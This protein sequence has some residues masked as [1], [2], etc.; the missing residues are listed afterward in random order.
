MA[1]IS[2][3]TSLGRRATS[4]VARAGASIGAEKAR[5]VWRELA[6]PSRRKTSAEAVADHFGFCAR[7]GA[8]LGAM[9]WPPGLASVVADG[10]GIVA[11]M[12]DDRPRYE[13]RL[14][15]IMFHARQTC[16]ACSIERRRTPVNPADLADAARLCFAHYRAAAAIAD[17]RQLAS[18]S[19]AALRAARSWSR[20]LA[21]GEGERAALGALRWLAG[22]AFDAGAADLPS[23]QA[24]A[25]C[26]VCL[27]AAHAL[28]KWLDSVST[29]MRLGLELHGLLPLC[30]MHIR[31]SA[32]HVGGREL[33]RQATELIEARLARGLAAN[34][35]AVQRDREQSSSVW[36]RRR[37]ASYV[38]GQRRRALRLPHCGACE[39]VDLASQ[40]AQGEV[41]DLVA[42]RRGRDML[43]RQGDLCL[44]HFGCVYMLCPH[45]EPRA[46]LAARQ[47]EALLR[48][49][50]ALTRGGDGAWTIAT[51]L[52][53]AAGAG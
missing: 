24:G 50:L 7:H 41:L 48:A 39:R 2:T 18:L 42:S 30:P 19:A 25:R 53:G 51:G 6:D 12:L 27:A 4:T 38:L 14:L 16:A 32:T 17:E 15:H 3:R 8:V 37:A 23:S 9:R 21:D 44:R 31:M 47:R 10:L 34:A 33:A 13:E 20:R 22:E 46:V 49:Q 40:K 29:A 5:G 28:E 26:P 43:A 45:G 35:R 1:S 52:L 36:Y 11:A